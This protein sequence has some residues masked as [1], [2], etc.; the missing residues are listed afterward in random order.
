MVCLGLQPKAAW[1]NSKHRSSRRARWPL[2]QHQSLTA[3]NMLQMPSELL[4]YT[5]MYVWQEKCITF[6]WSKVFRNE[7]Y[8]LE[9]EGGGATA[10]SSVDY[11]ALKIV[12]SRRS[13]VLKNAPSRIR[14]YLIELWRLSMKSWGG[15][16]NRFE[17]E[18]FPFGK[19]GLLFLP[20]AMFRNKDGA[21]AVA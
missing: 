14:M 15:G 10:I 3:A 4:S 11:D 8:K 6:N 9:G 2:D 1:W 19:R 20:S 16:G 12:I 7:F 21:I 18:I 5:F 17:Q 13:R